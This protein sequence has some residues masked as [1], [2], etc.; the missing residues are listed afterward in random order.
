MKDFLRNADYIR[1]LAK[2]QKLQEEEAFKAKKKQDQRRRKE[3]FLRYQQ[4]L[5]AYGSN[6][7][8]AAATSTKQS[9]FINTAG[10][11]LGTTSTSQSDFYNNATGLSVSF[12]IKATADTGLWVPYARRRFGKGGIEAQIQLSKTPVGGGFS[13][14]FQ[15]FFGDGFIGQ[16]GIANLGTPNMTQ[17]NHVVMTY[18]STAPALK[19]YLNGTA[20]DPDST[21]VSAKVMSGTSTGVKFGRDTIPSTPIG[22]TAYYDQIAIFK[23]TVLTQANVNSIYNSGCPTDNNI[24]SLNPD[25]LFEFDD[26]TESGGTW[27]IPDT[28]AN[29][30]GNYA[31]NSTDAEISTVTPC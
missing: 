9:L 8:T 30:N 26:A 29:A 20:H 28:G 21:P 2:K 13:G 17:W 4:H 7:G 12:W 14:G 27:T 23:N 18:D 11:F 15:F 10:G 25:T 6:T 24:S 22:D 5:Q 1:E 16:A 3:A 19:I 31:L